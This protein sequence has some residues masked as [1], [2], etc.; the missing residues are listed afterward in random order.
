MLP[1]QFIFILILY[2]IVSKKEENIVYVNKNYIAANKK[3]T[4]TKNKQF[5]YVANIKEFYALTIW[6]NL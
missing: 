6:H 3:K 2:E 5:L 4:C 1:T